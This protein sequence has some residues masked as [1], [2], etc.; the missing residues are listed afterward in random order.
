MSVSGTNDGLINKIIIDTNIF[1]LKG[2]IYIALADLTLWW[3]NS[4]T[5][6]TA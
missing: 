3:L 6:Q 2:K 5:S 4:I 1:E